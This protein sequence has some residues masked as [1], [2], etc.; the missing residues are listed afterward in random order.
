LVKFRV[1]GAARGA[2]RTGENAGARIAWKT[3]QSATISQKIT[4][5]GAIAGELHSPVNLI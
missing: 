1:Y 5:A 2:H 4:V 3:T